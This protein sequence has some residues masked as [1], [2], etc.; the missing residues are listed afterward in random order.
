MAFV[1]WVAGKLASK[2]APYVVIA[3]AALCVV[4]WGA[5]I[6][7]RLSLSAARGEAAETKANLDRASDANRTNLDTIE[8]LRAA[9]AEA[10]GQNEARDKAAAEIEAARRDYLVRLQRENLEL[11]KRRE[12]EYA[13]DAECAALRTTPVCRAVNDRLRALA[14]EDGDG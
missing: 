2:F 4:Q 1:A 10:I 8:S 13:R 12:T 6:Y 7:L 5:T 11:R 9:L 3:L 14:G